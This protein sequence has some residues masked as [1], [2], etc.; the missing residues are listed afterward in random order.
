MP[1][2]APPVFLWRNSFN[3]VYSNVLTAFEYLAERFSTRGFT[4]GRLVSVR[5]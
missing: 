2:A 3:A 1:L 4:T 5:F